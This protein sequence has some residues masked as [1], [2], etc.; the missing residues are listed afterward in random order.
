MCNALDSNRTEID[1]IE[2]AT[3]YRGK[4]KKEVSFCPI[5]LDKVALSVV[6]VSYCVPVFAHAASHVVGCC[7]KVA[8]AYAA[9]NVVGYHATVTAHAMLCATLGMLL[10][11]GCCIRD[12]AAAAMAAPPKFQQTKSR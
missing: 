4:S 7:T 11:F 8:A 6:L 5:I 9:L 1:P 10:Q 2:L 3:K 12:L